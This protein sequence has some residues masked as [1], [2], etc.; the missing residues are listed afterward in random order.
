MSQ[1]ELEKLGKKAE[2]NIANT[3]LSSAFELDSYERQKI[4]NY[5]RS[6]GVIQLTRPDTIM[7]FAADHEVGRSMIE[8]G[9]YYWNNVA[10][11]IGA[12]LPPH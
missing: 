5:L 11:T 8:P 10:N 4:T 1:K 7:H 3:A 6:S 9:K 2:T 12:V